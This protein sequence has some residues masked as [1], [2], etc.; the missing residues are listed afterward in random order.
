[1][2][3]VGDLATR[4]YWDDCWRAEVALP[5]EIHAFKNPA[6]GRLA[7][8]LRQRLPRG[9]RLLEIGCAA[10]AWMPFFAKELYCDLWGV[11]YSAA[12]LDLARRNLELLGLEAKLVLGD[13]LDARLPPGAFD[14]I[15]TDGLIEH[16]R[17]PSPIFRRC[18]EL[19]RPGG[20]Q[21]TVIPNLRGM[22]GA[23]QRLLDR[24]VYDVHVA[25]SPEDLDRIQ[26]DAGLVPL[27]AT[28]PFGV[29]CLGVL[30]WERRAR[31][32]SPAIRRSIAYVLQY[33]D[34]IVGWSTLWVDRSLD[35]VQTSPY[36]VSLYRK[37]GVLSDRPC[38]SAS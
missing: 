29:F 30:N 37:P 17:D 12:G 6:E 26:K 27:V 7:R 3:A 9:G 2:A 33:A 23:A 11:D 10:S 22:Y 19:L 21:V 35:S 34:R 28:R 38:E 31:S 14:V 25:F 15:F 16:Y 32:S 1:L 18:A 36:L 8:M 4:E 13:F 5:R 20:I 24:E